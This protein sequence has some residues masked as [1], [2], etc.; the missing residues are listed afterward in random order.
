M[1]HEIEIETG[2][3]KNSKLTS[4]SISWPAVTK[5][6]RNGPCPLKIGLWVDVEDELL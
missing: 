1:G 3:S 2:L 6:I 4:L 5:L